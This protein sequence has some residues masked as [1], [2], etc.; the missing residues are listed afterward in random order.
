MSQAGV[1]VTMNLEEANRE[2]LA[3]FGYIF[4]VCATG[5]TAEEMLAILRSRLPNTPEQEIHV[6]AEEQNKITRL[7]LERL[8]TG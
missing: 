2:Y 1:G 3:K 7:R 5:K 4:I 8:V 6:A